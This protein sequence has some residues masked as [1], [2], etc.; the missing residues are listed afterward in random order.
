[1]QAPVYNGYC[2][3]VVRAVYTT[4]QAAVQCWRYTWL[5]FRDVIFYFYR[6]KNTIVFCLSLSL[7]TFFP[8]FRHTRV[9]MTKTCDDGSPRVNLFLTTVSSGTGKI[10]D[11]C[12]GVEIAKIFCIRSNLTLGTRWEVYNFTR[13]TH[14]ILYL[15]DVWFIINVSTTIIYIMIIRGIAYLHVPFFEGEALFAPVK[16]PL[17]AAWR[18][19][20]TKL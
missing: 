13:Y 11:E 4:T 20:M 19:R 8:S 15:N 1:M 2:I 12:R 6:T 7:T 17:L 16:P 3:V 10:F 5:I 18:I 9:L 14:Y